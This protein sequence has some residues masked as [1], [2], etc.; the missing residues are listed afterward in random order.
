MVVSLAWRFQAQVGSFQANF[1]EVEKSYSTILSN[2][3]MRCANPPQAEDRCKTTRRPARPRTAPHRKTWVRRVAGWRYTSQPKARWNSLSRLNSSNTA[4]KAA[5]V[6]KNSRSE[7]R[8]VGKEC[9]SR[10][11]PYH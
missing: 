7:E 11:S 6:A 2:K 4:Q 8:R 1:G 9:R 10:W 5:S 3:G